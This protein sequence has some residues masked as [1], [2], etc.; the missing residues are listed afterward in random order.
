MALT[1]EFALDALPYLTGDVP[2]IRAAIKRRYED[3]QVDEIPA[4]APCGA[5]DH[6]YFTIEKTGLSTMRAVNDIA[7]ELDILSRDIGLA[8]LKDA[9]AV[10]RQTLSIEHI[11]PAEIASLRIPRIKVLST[12]RHTNKLKIGHLRGNRF[13]IKLREVDLGRLDDLRAICAVLQHRGVPNY[14]GQQRFGSRGDTW[15]IGRAVLQGDHV[16]ALD[17]MLGRPG[18]HDSGDVLRARQLY[19]TGKFAAAARA[20]PYGFRDNAR[21]CRAMEKSGGKHKRAFFAIDQRLKKFYVNA[22]QSYLFNLVLA[23]RIAEIDQVREGDLAFKHDN[24][25][26]FRVT[27]AAA[28]SSRAAAFEI[29]PTGPI[30]GFRMTEA[31]GPTR[32]EESAVLAGEGLSLDDFRRGRDMKFHGS[33]RPLRFRPDGLELEP[34][35][36]EHGAFL[37]LRFSLASGCYATMIFREVCKGLLEEGLQDEPEDS[38]SPEAA[39]EA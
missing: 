31:G 30:F 17:L 38:A 25:A 12:T 22:Y 21:A 27:D 35:A 9:R 26:V 7:Q 3:F 37:E 5:G 10:T 1:A 36:D 6:V 14:F 2:P 23:G 24:G 19:D 8:G 18:P 34:G 13:R 16:T 33:R 11:D 20:W 28:E 29:S 39:G 32:E 15:Q 4:Y